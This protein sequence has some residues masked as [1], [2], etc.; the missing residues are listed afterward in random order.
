MYKSE[1]AYKTISEVSQILNVPQ[2]VLRFWESRFNQIKPLKRGGGRR[3]YKPEDVV[4]LQGIK[5]LLYNDGYTIRGVQ[6][7]LKEQGLKSVLTVGVNVSSSDKE[8]AD[9]SKTTEFSSFTQSENLSS[10][11]GNNKSSFSEKLSDI[12]EN[13]LTMKKALDSSDD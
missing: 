6:R 13:L 8:S 5:F 12:K 11:A 10:V 1:N 2:H 9:D 4:L 7:V 3:Y